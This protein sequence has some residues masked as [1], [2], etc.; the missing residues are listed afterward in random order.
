MPRVHFV[1]KA[2]KDVKNSDIKKGESYFWW[3]FNYGAKHVSRTKPKQ[4]Q[5]TQSAFLSQIYDIQDRIEGMATDSDFET[6]ISDIVSE[7]ENLRDECE[8]KR[9]NM[10]DQLQ[11]SGSGEILQNR[12]DS[13]QEMIDELEGIDKDVE[14]PNEEEAKDDV[15]EK[16][17]GE[18]EEDYQNRLKERKEEMLEERQQEILD[19]IQA[20][21]YNG[22]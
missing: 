8:D 15:G 11:D 4:S 7:L 19:E 6:E 16:E 3:K 22:E 1:K 20:V 12:V 17:E 9:S 2:R 18:N 5:L 10:P 13:V 21:S 14:E